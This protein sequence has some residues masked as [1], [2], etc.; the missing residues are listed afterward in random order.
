MEKKKSGFKTRAHD[1]A[2]KPFVMLIEEPFVSSIPNR[3]FDDGQLTRFYRM[4]LVLTLYMSA[5]YGQS[6]GSQAAQ[7]LR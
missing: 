7:T 5:L 3:P 2:V 4:L 1:V 6:R